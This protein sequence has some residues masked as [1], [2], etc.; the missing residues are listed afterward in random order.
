MHELY[1]NIDRAGGSEMKCFIGRMVNLLCLLVGWAF[2]IDAAYR[3][4]PTEQVKQPTQVPASMAKVQAPNLAMQY[5]FDPAKSSMLGMQKNAGKPGVSGRANARTSSDDVNWAL[6]DVSVEDI[7]ATPVAVSSQQTTQSQGVGARMLSQS[8]AMQDIQPVR[9]WE[10]SK[11]VIPAKYSKQGSVSIQQPVE[12]F[13]GNVPVEQ[14]AQTVLPVTGSKFDQPIK[15]AREGSVVSKQPVE[16]FVNNVPVEQFVPQ[17]QIVETAKGY[18]KDA[19]RSPVVVQQPVENFAG[20]APVEQVA[21][22]ALP[23]V[24]NFDVGLQVRIDMDRASQDN[25]QILGKQFVQKNPLSRYHSAVK[26]NVE[27]SG[28]QVKVIE[29]DVVAQE[30]IEILASEPIVITEQVVQQPQGPKIDLTQVRARVAKPSQ[31]ELEQGVNAPASQVKVYTVKQN[32]LQ[33]RFAAEEQAQVDAIKPYNRQATEEFNAKWPAV[34]QDYKQKRQALNIPIDEGRVDLLKSQTKKQILD[35][36]LEDNKTQID[37]F[38]QRKIAEFDANNIFQAPTKKL[39]TAHQLVNSNNLAQKEIENKMR[40]FAEQEARDAILNPRI[41]AKFPENLQEVWVEDFKHDYELKNQKK[42]PLSE[43]N[44]ALAEHKKSIELELYSTL[45][46]E[47][48]LGIKQ[49]GNKAV[50]QWKEKQQNRS[51]SPQTVAADVSRSVTPE[52]S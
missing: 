21:Q 46:A 47:E 8:L 51:A 43:V 45:S 49:A 19:R 20:N 7:D 39:G 2:N 38:V 18:F 50:S 14:S 10:M 16:S 41:L 40:S 32:Y 30:P 12:N 29:Q 23:V 48:K 31:A 26:P 13:A 4:L 22:T 25:A 6:S 36:I 33:D 11:K 5:K 37:T 3:L 35:K 42:A 34:L 15:I 1:K 44:K 27:R 28:K 24:G 9:P 52:L 17:Q